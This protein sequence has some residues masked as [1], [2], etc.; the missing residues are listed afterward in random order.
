[1]GVIEKVARK[2]RE[3][4]NHSIVERAVEKLQREDDDDLDDPVVEA[5][6]VLP[7]GPPPSASEPMPGG[8]QRTSRRV[9]IDGHRLRS[10]EIIMP[11]AER[12]RLAEE[13]RV[14]K[15]PLILKAFAKGPQAV[16]NGNMIMVTSAGPKEGKTF[17]A[18]NLA[19]S[20]AAERDLTVLLVDADLSRPQILAKLGLEAETGLVDVL[21]DSSVDLADVLLRTNFDNLSLLPAGRTNPDC[22]ELLASTRMEALVQEIARRYADRVIIF[23]SPPILASSEPSVLALHMGQIVF[24]VEAAR[25]SE[26]MV[27]ASLDL[28]SFCDNIGFVLNKARASAG[29]EQF[30]SY[31]KLRHA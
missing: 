14:I 17:T 11:G 19:M 3:L 7:S 6:P 23:D 1:M 18:I 28:I 27:K 15:R 5:E 10:S 30:G 8:G 4:R 12:T 24:V 9:T 20:I 29:V 21:A 16:K 25:T 22:T 2:H 31:Y 26:A 13:F